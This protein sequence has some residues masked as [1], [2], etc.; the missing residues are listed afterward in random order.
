[1]WIG[2]GLVVGVV[3]VLA[4]GGLLMAFETNSMAGSSKLDD[5][6]M[7]IPHGKVGDQVTYRTIVTEHPG[8]P[9]TDDFERG[10]EVAKIDATP[11][12]AGNVHETVAIIT[13]PHEGDA[14]LWALYQDLGR[15]GVQQTRTYRIDLDSRAIVS[16]TFEYD[17]PVAPTL[18]GTT[19]QVGANTV[20]GPI[21]WGLN[22]GPGAY[23]AYPGP[24]NGTQW[25]WPVVFQGA[26]LQLGRDLGPLSD[27]ALAHEMNSWT[28]EG[29]VVLDAFEYDAQVI[30][31]RMVGP[32]DSYD[33]RYEGCVVFRAASWTYGYETLT[34]LGWRVPFDREMCFLLDV[35]VTADVP[36]PV[37]AETRISVDGEPML[38]RQESL[39]AFRSGAKAIP[40]GA[41]V[42]QP[43]FEGREGTPEIIGSLD[44]AHP[45]EGEDSPLGFGL[46]EALALVEEAVTLPRLAAWKA[47][48]PGHFLVG[49]E[50]TPREHGLLRW[51]FVY[52]DAPTS[53]FVVWVQKSPG[54]AAQPPVEAGEFE[55]HEP[56]LDNYSNYAS[57]SH[58]ARAW[59]EAM[60]RT[61]DDP[62]PNLVRW[63]WEY[64]PPQLDCS[65]AGG[66]ALK[67]PAMRWQS[68]D[69]MLVGY[70]SGVWSSGPAET[71]P[72][73]PLQQRDDSYL[74]AFI[75]SGFSRLMSG[76]AQE[77]GTFEP[78]LG[79]G[80]PPE[81][82]AALV[83]ATGAVSEAGP[84]VLVTSSLLALFLFVYFLPLIRE[85]GLKLLFL[86]PAYAKL[87]KKHLLNN[88]Y[89]DAI[90]TLVKDEPGITASEMHKTVGGSL[91]TV[92]Y[93]LRVLEKNNVMTSLVDGRY[94]RFFP[95]EDVSWGER[96][97][98]AA[99]RS[100]KTRLIYEAIHSE[101][102]LA[103][104]ELSKRAG[105]SR[106]GVYWHVDRLE[107]V[108][109][110]SHDKERGR[111][112]FYASDPHFL[113]GDGGNVGGPEVA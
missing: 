92:V 110:V 50:L 45:L 29:A 95:A 23:E 81:E 80:S 51:T 69:H 8:G 79:S 17:S 96:G 77:F 46:T 75:P 106:P 56:I 68:S 108:G 27:L 44:V 31:R 14:G 100:A 71:S 52:G 85:H 13:S 62:A 76:H 39:A 84:A 58:T 97:R 67:D 4:L 55:L 53:A 33:V 74:V 65:T 99:L 7:T 83:E 19:Q 90:A 109:L 63:G 78:L 36:Y 6:P 89:R 86:I 64:E 59:A 73:H 105:I 113:P 5:S 93:H 72:T 112:R 102:G 15:Q 35:W 48:H 91:S 34:W 47:E 3:G 41:F 10:F 21:G 61:P 24:R 94:K 11:D 104:A 38:F 22:P 87:R 54:Q 9:S 107:R 25:F 60:G 37:L 28:L 32:H 30:D 42:P 82:P 1:M 101:P 12:A 70:T 16:R 57:I 66:C 111:T 103:P 40:W 49:Y 43:Y 88:E 2:K 98:L 18:L 20:Y 26:T